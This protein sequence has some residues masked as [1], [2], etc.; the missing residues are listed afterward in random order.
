MEERQAVEDEKILTDEEITAL[1]TG[2]YFGG[3]GLDN[4][5]EWYYYKVADK[6]LGGVYDGF[7]DTPTDLQTKINKARLA[8]DRDLLKELSEQQEVLIAM[9]KNVF[10]FSAAKTYEQQK[11]LRSLLFADGK[12]KSFTEFKKEAEKIVK[13]F[14]EQWL[15]TEYQN[16]INQAISA[17]E[18]SVYI[19]EQ[20]LFPLLR[21][22]TQEDDRVR[23]KHQKLNN[24]TKAVNDPFWASYYPPIEWNCR[25]F[26]VQVSERDTRNEATIEEINKIVPEYFRFN[27]WL[28]KIVFGLKHPYFVVS[29]EEE[30]RKKRNFGLPIPMLNV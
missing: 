3:Y 24:K 28:D 29:D 16:A 14:N 17:K 7:G 22:K 13:V 30:R 4:L 11:Q 23:E 9:R 20:E 8:G 19:E 1:L 5:P 15:Q 26:V 6:L 27:A 2:F 10:E 12:I 21:Y 25:C 18:Y